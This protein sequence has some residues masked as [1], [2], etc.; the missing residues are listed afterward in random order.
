MD[1]RCIG[2]PLCG[3]TPEE[4]W[5]EDFLWLLASEILPNGESVPLLRI[6]DCYYTSVARGKEETTGAR[7]R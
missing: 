5:R 2:S 4:N 3:N 1:T 6:H 7:G